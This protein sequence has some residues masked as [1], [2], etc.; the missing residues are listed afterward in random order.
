M[1]VFL[2]PCLVEEEKTCMPKTAHTEMRGSLP[3]PFPR[4][5]RLGVEGETLFLTERKET[6]KVTL[7]RRF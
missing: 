2:G 6:V 7:V 3:T 5:G 4:A 1:D